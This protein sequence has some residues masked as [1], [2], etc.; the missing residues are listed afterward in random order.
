[1]PLLHQVSEE[2][3]LPVCRYYTHKNVYD[4]AVSL[5]LTAHV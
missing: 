4:V 5:C 2:G 1:M 3:T